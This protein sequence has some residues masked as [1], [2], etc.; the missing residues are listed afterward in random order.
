MSESNLEIISL[1]GIDFLPIVTGSGRGNT[2]D[3]G[4]SVQL[5]QAR[6][7]VPNN[8]LQFGGFGLSDGDIV[9][10]ARTSLEIDHGGDRSRKDVQC[11]IR[12][13]PGLGEAVIFDGQT[14]V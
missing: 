11:G 2:D 6:V 8:S 5:P 7:F 3:G 10:S 13:R 12:A 4:I 1:S 9:S 14:T